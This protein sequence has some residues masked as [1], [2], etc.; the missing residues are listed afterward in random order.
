MKSTEMTKEQG[1]CLALERASTW[2]SIHADHR[3]KMM[4][5]YLILLGA[6]LAGFASA[7]EK[8]LPGFGIILSFVL[9]IVTYCFKQLDRR[10]SQLLKLA[11][12]ALLKIESAIFEATK[13]AET[14]LVLGA[15]N[16]GR[17]PSYRYIFN[18]LFGTGAV[19]GVL[20]C[21]YFSFRLLGFVE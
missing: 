10:T 13:I 6:I 9:L 20:G 19:L 12:A 11:E 16:K 21:F 1:F 18:I 15:E 17:V 4:N 2:F 3:M 14:R 7:L 8:D 5:F